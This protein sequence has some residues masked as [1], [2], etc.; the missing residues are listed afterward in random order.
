MFGY[1][2]AYIYIYVYNVWCMYICT[3]L[4]VYIHVYDTHIYPLYMYVCVSH[5]VNMSQI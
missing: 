3:Y 2:K 1:T 5:T 4:Y